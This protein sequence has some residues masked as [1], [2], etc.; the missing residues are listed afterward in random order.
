VVALRRRGRE[1]LEQRLCGPPSTWDKVLNVPLHG[2]MV[3]CDGVERDLV[4]SIP[5]LE[6]VRM[7]EFSGAITAK[8]LGADQVF[9]DSYIVVARATS[10][11]PRPGLLAFCCCPWVLSS[12][13]TTRY[14]S[15]TKYKGA[16]RPGQRAHVSWRALSRSLIVS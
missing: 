4:L 9:G 2:M 13:K 8:G 7:F 14:E 11:N 15:A 5:H 1:G 3:R 16:H 6:T 12:A 10:A